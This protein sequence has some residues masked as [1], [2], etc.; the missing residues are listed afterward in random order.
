[1]KQE[2]K[3]E[4]KQEVKEEKTLVLAKTFFCCPAYL[5]YLRV[6]K[7]MTF[8]QGC[9]RKIGVLPWSIK[10]DGGVSVLVFPLHGWYDRINSMVIQQL[11]MVPVQVGFLWPGCFFFMSSKFP[12]SGSD[13]CL[14]KQ[15]QLRF[16]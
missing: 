13:S 9:Q 10:F 8:R 4:V 16:G 2:V 5:R 7:I 15:I 14:K 11:D 6:A 3:E 12:N 1:M